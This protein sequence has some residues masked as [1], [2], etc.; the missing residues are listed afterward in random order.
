MN[1]Q[2]LD[3]KL[4][5][6]NDKHVTELQRVISEARFRNTIQQDKVNKWKEWRDQMEL[7]DMRK[8]WDN[9]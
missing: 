8:M 6:S 5:E 1:L 3:I 7:E 4:K 2:K 9:E